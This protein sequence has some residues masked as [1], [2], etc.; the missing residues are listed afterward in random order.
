MFSSA[1]LSRETG[2]NVFLKA[3]LF[4]RTGSFKP[5]GVLTKL[6]SLTPEER[7]G[8]V[9]TAS[10]GNAA[11]ALAYSGA[12][13]GIDASSSCGRERASSRSRPSRATAARSTRR[14]RTRPRS[15]T[16]QAEFAAQGRTFVHPF[17]DDVVI[18]G[19]ASLGREIVEDCPDVDV[20]VVPDRRRRAR[21]RDRVG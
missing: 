12:L 16:A 21:L 11:A 1:T 10:A 17:D 3:E 6:A 2:A 13:E 19:Q 4:Q 15:S 18:A 8:G 5:R 14:P 7:A 9:I 20:V